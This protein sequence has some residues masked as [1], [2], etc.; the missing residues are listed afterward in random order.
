VSVPDCCVE[1]FFD[2]IAFH[3]HD[4]YSGGSPLRRFSQQNNVPV[5]RTQVTGSRLK[6]R[7]SLSTYV[8]KAMQLAYDDCKEIK[9]DKDPK[10]K[11]KDWKKENPSKRVHAVN[12]IKEQVNGNQRDVKSIFSSVPDTVSNDFE[13]ILAKWERKKLKP[14]LGDTRDQII[15]DF[16]NRF[17]MGDDIR[18]EGNEEAV[19]IL[20]EACESIFESI[21]H[22]NAR[23]NR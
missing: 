14:L 13:E 19:A 17:V 15:R 21:D 20:R 23:P 5:R 18:S 3:H 11:D 6:G 9:K 12:R 10:W 7:D 16:D 2:R 22:L 8:D 1:S 4:S